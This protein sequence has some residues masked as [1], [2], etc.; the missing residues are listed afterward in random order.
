MKQLGQQMERIR[1]CFSTMLLL[2]KLQ[3]DFSPQLAVIF[4]AWPVSCECSDSSFILATS[5]WLNEALLLRAGFKSPSIPQDWRNFRSQMPIFASFSIC[6]YLWWVD[7]CGC[8]F[9]DSSRPETHARGGYRLSY[10]TSRVFFC[11]WISDIGR[12]NLIKAREDWP[13]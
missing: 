8:V 2:G 6:G 12:G 13:I 1:D 9:L 10:I 3:L 7:D 4:T 5:I 11:F